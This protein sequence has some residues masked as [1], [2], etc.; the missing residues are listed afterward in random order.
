VV[1]VVVAGAADSL[2]LSSPPVQDIKDNEKS[3]VTTINDFF[4]NAYFY[5]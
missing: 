1:S 4:I 2:F 5:L 3:A